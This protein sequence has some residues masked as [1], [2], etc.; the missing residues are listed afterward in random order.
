MIWNIHHHQCRIPPK[1]TKEIKL[2]SFMKNFHE[3]QVQISESH[4]NKKETPVPVSHCN[5][6][7]SEGGRTITQNYFKYDTLIS[8]FPTT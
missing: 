5:I 4:E 6:L 2:E 3:F 7:M 8:S 1:K